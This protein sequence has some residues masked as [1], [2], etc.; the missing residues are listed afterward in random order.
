MEHSCLQLLLPENK[1]VKR[2][3]INDKE[4]EFTVPEILSSRSQIICHS[5]SIDDTARNQDSR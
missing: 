1:G 2:V 4:M 3:I 5:I